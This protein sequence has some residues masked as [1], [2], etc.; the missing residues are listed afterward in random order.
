MFVLF[1]LFT[2]SIA[3]AKTYYVAPNGSDSNDGSINTPFQTIQKAADVVNPGDTVIVKDGIYTAAPGKNWIVKLNR[4]G[5]PDAWVTF[6]SENKW[7]AVL[8]GKLEVEWCIVSGSNVNYIR[9]ENFQIT[10]SRD[11]G[12][13][14]G[15]GRHHYYIYG[16]EF[17]HC[18][19]IEKCCGS[20][21]G[22]GK[23]CG[24]RSG[25]YQGKGTSNFTYDS[26][27]F[28]HIGRI[29]VDG[30]GGNYNHDHGIYC[31]GDNTL[32][33]NNLFYE[34]KAGWGVALAEGHSGNI[35]SNNTFVGPNPG[36]DGLLLV[37]YDQKDAIIQNNIFFN[38]RNCAINTI[39]GETQKNI[40][41]RNNLT[42]PVSYTCSKDDYSGFI[43]KNNIEGLDPLFVD[44]ENYDFRLQ[45]DSPAIDAGYS[46]GTPPYDHDGNKR[47]SGGRVDIG[48]YEYGGVQGNVTPTAKIKADVLGGEAPLTVNF[49][50]SQS[51]DRDGR[52]QSYAW[53][54][55]DGQT[56]QEQIP[57]PHIYNQV[58]DYL[59]TLT[60]TDD[61]GAVD[62][63]KITI[64]VIEAGSYI[65]QYLESENGEINSSMQI[66]NDD[67]ASNGAY[68]HTP[69]GV[70]NTSTPVAEV[71]YQIKLANSG[72]Y[73]LWLR[74]YAPNKNSDAI[75]I[76]FNGSFNR[77]FPENTKKYEWVKA[78]D[79]YNLNANT[80]QIN[81][82]H[83][84]EQAR[85]D[86]ILVTNDP[87]YIPAA[88][89]ELPTATITV[90][91]PSPTK[92]GNVEVT[93]TTSKRLVR[94]PLLLFTESDN[95]TTIVNL[96]GAIPGNSFTGTFV[97]DGGVADGFGQFSLPT[98]ALVDVDGKKGDQII[99]GATVVIDK[100]PP[101]RPK[102]LKASLTN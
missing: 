85:A 5:S 62:T 99:S 23:P 20:G 9:I 98:D 59:V 86:I 79:T 56:S 46:Q 47:P 39:R 84:E 30:C 80:N 48:A 14:V 29:P 90:S 92:A 65:Y 71:T 42:F 7:G 53:N 8:D 70:G 41:F 6:R 57:S 51:I 82:G 22:G 35:V 96:D 81:I 60:V 31:H 45:A 87:N 66:G 91:D 100:T 73:S 4:G 74:M 54:F 1:I 24:G 67:S 3:V 50:G 19:N 10:R 49:D 94:V 27:V 58:G 102:N 12:L 55:G 68:I 88:A 26:N 28:H 101:S 75:Y 44:V 43:W 16:N 36:R 40:I 77:I 21:A 69:V 2:A 78:G 18:G 13:Q 93:L 25:A 64:S 61:R 34:N 89:D 17:H 38:S 76:G 95:T 32:I 97:I 11:T 15:G 63:D 83:G 33:I 52:I 72:N 37:D